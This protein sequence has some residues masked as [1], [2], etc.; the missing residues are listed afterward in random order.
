MVIFYVPGAYLNSDMPEDKLILLKIE[1]K[2]VEIMCKLNPEHK[3]N[4]CVENRVKV[5]YL[6]LL[7]SLYVFMESALLCYD[8]Y[9]KTLKS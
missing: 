9:S 8:I 7:K 1:G 2:F 4:V 3:K 6:Q 5:L